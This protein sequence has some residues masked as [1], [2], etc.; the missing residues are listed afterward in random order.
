MSPFRLFGRP[1]TEADAEAAFSPA[2]HAASHGAAPA[3]RPPHSGGSARRPVD[4]AE[5]KARGRRGTRPTPPGDGAPESTSWQA[6]GTRWA[7]GSTAWG[8]APPRYG[9]NGSWGPPGNATAT[10]AGDPGPP[11]VPV[12]AATRWGAATGHAAGRSRS[13]SW[14]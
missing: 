3:Y 14:G 11:P 2:G 10:A 9:A 6:A 8:A 5:R 1:D 12:G 7:A 13:P 4:R